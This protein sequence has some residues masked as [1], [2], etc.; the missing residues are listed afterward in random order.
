MITP[1]TLIRCIN[2]ATEEEVFRY[3]AA[4]KDDVKGAVARARRASQK[5]KE[6]SAWKR[7]DFLSEAA[8]TIRSRKEEFAKIITQEMGKTIKESVAE[9]EKCARG[10]DY[11]AENGPKFL[12]DELVQTEA[13]E[14]YIAF[15]PLGVIASI[16][17]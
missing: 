16:M 3:R 15:E 8:S 2:P 14:S 6:H 12:E 4:S 9:V 13:A 17:T 5:W 1:D 10:V 11:Y 7:S